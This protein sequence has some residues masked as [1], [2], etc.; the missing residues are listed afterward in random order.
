MTFID[1][2]LTPE[3]LAAIQRDGLRWTVRH[4]WDH[5]PFYR[6]KLAA[7]GLADPEEIRG[8][9]DLARLPLLDKE[10]LQAGYPFPLRAAPFEDL[11]RI[12]ASSGTTG[13]R[14]VLCYTRQDVDDWS[15]IFARCYELAGLT[16]LDR[17]QIAV[18]YGLWTAGAGF[19]AGCERFGALAVPVGPANAEMH[20]E[21]MVDLETTV[22]CSTA[23]MALLMAEEIERRG[24]RERI[25]LE[26]VI[27]GAERCSDA[28]RQRIRELLG[29]AHIFD[30][31]GL[32]ELYGPG[33]GLDCERHRGIHYWS[34]RFIFETIDPA[35]LA[36]VPPGEAGELVVTT[37]RKQGA[38]LIRYRTH[39]ITRLIPGTC[40]CGVPFPRHDRIEGRTDDMFIYRAVNIYPSQVDHLLGGI[41]GIGSEFQIHLRA[42]ENG[43]DM[44]LIRVERAEGAA[45]DEDAALAERVATDVRRKILVRSQVEIV[46]PGALGRTPR[47]SQRVFDHR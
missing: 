20:C 35:T 38:P 21:M 5:S 30:I 39:D 7:A 32:T 45:A 31:Y 37:L 6:D 26:K 19:Q 12:H 33:T 36:P 44:M 8:L 10:E 40:A 43:R 3:C 29:V 25:R 24:L 2:T 16:R 27:L 41:A 11:V 22:F 9:D 46:D 47:K 28:M 23:S 17:V 34:D 42:R 15:E 1:R 13:K 4:A 14:K 18:G